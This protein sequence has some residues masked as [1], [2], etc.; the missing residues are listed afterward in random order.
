MSEYFYIFL[1]VALVFGG[2]VLLLIG[3]IYAGW[4]L[5]LRWAGQRFFNSFDDRFD[6]VTRNQR[7]PR[8]RKDVSRNER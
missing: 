3:A 1:D 2:C 8:T 4:Y 6:A 5:T 7:Q